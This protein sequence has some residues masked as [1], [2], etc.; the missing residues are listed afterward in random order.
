MTRVLLSLGHIQVEVHVQIGG[1][2]YRAV[3]VQHVANVDDS[4]DDTVLYASI[5]HG[6]DGIVRYAQ[7]H[8]WMR[9]TVRYNDTNVRFAHHRVERLEC[10]ARV[11]IEDLDSLNQLGLDAVHLTTR[12]IENVESRLDD[13]TGEKGA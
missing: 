3:H 4:T 8:R 12:S 6:F 2:R 9:V 10:C 13:I 7:L 11:V 1:Q 5:E